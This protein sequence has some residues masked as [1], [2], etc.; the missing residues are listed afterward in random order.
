MKV[1]IRSHL[2]GEEFAR[3]TDSIVIQDHMII[4]LTNTVHFIN[5]YDKS[6]NT[7]AHI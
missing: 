2:G 3:L 6:I 4:D 7:C 1:P 5:A